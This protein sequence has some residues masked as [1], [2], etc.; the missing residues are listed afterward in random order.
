MSFWDILYTLLLKPLQLLFEIIYM[1][2]NRV[3][4]NPGLSIIILSLVMN[5]LVLPLY[6]R[7]DAMQEEERDM[8]MKLRK[9]VAHIKKTF[10]GDERM[11]ML[12]TYY[13]QN[14]YKPT[15][16]LRGAVSLFLEIPF[17]I[18]AYQFLS[19]LQ[20]LHGVSF[21]PVS[22]LGKPDGLLSVAGVSINVLP[23]IM[24]AI[25][26]VS[27]VIFTKGSSLKSKIQL[28]AMAAFFLVFLYASPSGLVFYW[29]LNNTFSLVKTIFYKLKNPGKILSILF[30]A[31]GAFLLVYGLFFYSRPSLKR[32][33]LFVGCGVLFQLPLLYTLLKKKLRFNLKFTQE[34]ANKKAFFAGGLFLSVLVG[35]V[36]PSA[37]I[38]ASPQEFID[39]NYFY[40]P[41][42]FIASSFCFAVGT[43]V[44]WLGVFYWLAKPSSRVLF[45]RAV[46]ILS[47]VAIVDYMFFGKDLGNLSANLKYDNGLDFTWKAQLLNAAVLVVVALV[48]YLVF[49]RW[50]KQVFP[51]LLVGS[52]ALGCMSALNMV[53]INTSVGEFQAQGGA[54]NAETARFSL[55][56]KGKNVVVLMLDRAMGQYVPYIFNEKPELKEQFSGFTYYSNVIS[57]GG[58]TNFG[59]PALWGGY[60][61][62]PVE[63]NRRDG[64]SLVEKHNEALKVLPVLFDQNGY[65]VT[66]CDPT[67]ANYQWIPDLSIYDDYPDIQK[68]ITKGRFTDAATKER[69]IQSNIRNF[70]CY[71]LL[72]SAPLCFQEVLYD[73]GSYNQGNSGALY[74]QQKREGRF[75]SAGISSLFM[76]CYNVLLN[77]PGMT[78]ITDEGVNTFLFMTNDTTH[79]P[80][81]L[82]EPDYEPA[83][84]VDNTEYEKNHS[85]RFT[86]NGRTLKMETEKQMIHYQTNMAAMLQLGKWFDYMRE[87]GVYDNT[88]IILVS[89]HGK[90]LNQD[91]SFKLADGT[92]K[93]LYYPLLM[94]KDFDSKGFV[95]SEEFMTNGDVPTLAAEEIIENPVNP[96]TGKK[97][98]SSEKTAHDQ[99]IINSDEWETGINNGKTF[100]PSKWYSVHD[101]IWNQDNWKKVADKAVL[102]P[103][104]EQK[105][106][107]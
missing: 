75:I 80:M 30:S 70:F 4:G 97:I 18:A 28:Y 72:K 9:G 17:F 11:M 19:G 20:L 54:D 13:R 107:K 26:L 66:V 12:Q 102:P 39:I 42:W 31:A 44:I 56:K 43:F 57:F 103:E 95:T 14:H 23:I 53:S 47:G 41:L 90:D 10:S 84:Y 37:V 98:D 7:A 21:G 100:L 101:D 40:H 58:Y 59:S 38:K 3:I 78:D 5:F 62:T 16:V 93:A 52:V 2:A 55:S 61:Y 50:K 35:V 1:M 73:G 79:E 6:R 87:N 83:Q 25:N 48:F 68:Y 77:L 89:D 22:D 51:I 34:T 63:M 60:E 82:Q 64:E 92:D 74:S 76:D 67:Y 15:Y 71:G 29:T 104:C 46:W 27:C 91:N 8:E 86:L 105:T 45:D 69:H 33:A 96:F 65:D 36:I 49:R 81:L 88:R 32:I 94:V 99:Y 106:E 85:G 24:T